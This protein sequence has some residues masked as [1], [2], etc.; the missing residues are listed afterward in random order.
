MS[1]NEKAILPTSTPP[2]PTRSLNTGRNRLIFVVVFFTIFTPARYLINHFLGRHECHHNHIKYTAAELAVSKCP[3]QPAPLNVGNDWNPLIDETYASLAAK[4]LSKA[5]QTPTESYDDF[6]LDP[7]D[8]IWE[9]F[10]AIHHFL[11]IEYP[12]LM[13]DPVKHEMVNTHGHLFTWEGSDPK[14]QPIL[15]MAH[16]DVVPVLPETLHQW[17]HPP[18]EGTITVDDSPS[19]PG[20]WLW[21][22]GVSDCKN[23][24]LGIF[25][26][27]ERL[28]TEGFKP[29]RTILVANGFDEEVSATY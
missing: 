10:N 13:N 15:L 5:V 8:P 27:M 22:R 20:T 21:G 26:A 1:V 25:G 14:L 3:V 9:K 7:S 16:T 23:Q 18:F 17:I 4:R 28:V 2:P 11:E 19:T 6:P 24:L 12:K 29:G